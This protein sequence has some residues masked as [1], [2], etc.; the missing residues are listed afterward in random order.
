MPAHV[1]W[2]RGAGRVYSIGEVCE[3]SGLS[4]R[5]VRYYEEQG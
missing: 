3:R 5:T 4:P 2:Q 1:N